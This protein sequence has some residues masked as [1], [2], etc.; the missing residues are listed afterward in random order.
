MDRLLPRRRLRTRIARQAGLFALLLAALAGGQDL[1][2]EATGWGP[3]IEAAHRAADRAAV[4]KGI[5]LVVTSE[6]EIQDFQT[7]RD[8]VLTR[9]EGAVRASEIV[10]KSQGPD[11]AWEVSVKARV[12]RIRLRDDL[13]ALRILRAAVG[14][15]RIALLLQTSPEGL[16]GADGVAASA[17]V[18]ALRDRE[19]EVVEPSEALRAKWARRLARAGE[20]TTGIA[21]AMGSDL[22]AEV[23]LAGKAQAVAADLSSHP[24][25]RNTGMNSVSGTVSLRAVDVQ[26]RE[27]LASRS[28][29]A[30]AVHPQVATAE[31]LALEKAARLVLEDSVDG[32]LAQLTR[33]WQ[34]KANN[35][36]LLRLRIRNV[37]NQAAAQIVTEEL[38]SESVDVQTRRFAEGTLFLDATWRGNAEDFRAAMDG[39]RI[40]K[41]RNRLVVVSAEG[42]SVLLD[43]Q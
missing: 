43:V 5:G 2:V 18:R 8:V 10:A 11:G 19:F 30:P 23:V 29:Q 41:E 37:P 27:I 6:T 24:Y 16:P 17:L 28:A 35:G 4:E 31:A 40:N 7:R 25:F 33:T 20:A 42:N 32:I 13:R 38:R 12:S 3:T 9:T 15:P 36:T 34:D 1:D 21:T 26:T 22:G 39:R 14:R